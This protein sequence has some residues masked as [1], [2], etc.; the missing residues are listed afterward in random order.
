[1]KY[2]EKILSKKMIFP[3]FNEGSG[4][5]FFDG[6]GHVTSEWLKNFKTRKLQHQAI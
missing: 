6:P 2:S 4:A 3:V 1:M 5:A